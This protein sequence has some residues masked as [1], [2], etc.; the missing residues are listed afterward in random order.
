MNLTVFVEVV[1]AVLALALVSLVALRVELTR[2]QGGK[3]LA[4]TAL[5]I[6]PGLATWVGFNGQMDRA[7]STRFCLSCHVMSDYGKSLYVDDPSFVPAV[8]FQNRFVPRSHACY[9]CHTDY[10]LFGPFHS[11][12]RGVRHVYVQ[13]FGTIPQPDKIKLYTP[14]N[15]RECLHCH[16]DTRRFDE[17]TE[18]KKTPTMLAEIYSGKLSCLGS[19]FHDTIHDIKDLQY[20]TFWKERSPHATPAH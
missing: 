18:H 8:H 4:F 19:H 15:N 14:Y 12:L 5:F 16:A 11:K 17:A 9:T 6:L 3:I 1:L 2:A 10:T 13:Y 7:E 20:A